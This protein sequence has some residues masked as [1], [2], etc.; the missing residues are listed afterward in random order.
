MAKKA[1]AATKAKPKQKKKEVIKVN[2]L[3]DSMDQVSTVVG[4]SIEDSEKF[5]GRE[6]GWKPAG[7]RVRKQLKEIMD[8][9]KV[10]RKYISQVKKEEK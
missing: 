9:C 6:R 10:L 2:S 4:E 5:D 3:A 8:L 7:G 1:A